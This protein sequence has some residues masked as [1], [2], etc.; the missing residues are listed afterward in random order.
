MRGKA[1]RLRAPLAAIPEPKAKEEEPQSEP[2]G[3]WGRHHRTTSA[4]AGTEVSSYIGGLRRT[5]AVPLQIVTQPS[6]NG[7]IH[8]GRQA[9]SSSAT[10][11]PRVNSTPPSD[12]SA[13]LA[14]ELHDRIN[15]FVQTGTS[16]S[17]ALTEDCKIFFQENSSADVRICTLPPDGIEMH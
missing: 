4:V 8:L 16:N 2:S 6:E 14:R 13:K 1:N 10:N 7:R 17:A 11:S 5:E 15:S 12:L 9:R 3:M